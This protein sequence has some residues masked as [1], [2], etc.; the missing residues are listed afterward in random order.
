MNRESDKLENYAGTR[1]TRRGGEWGAYRQCDVQVIVLRTKLVQGINEDK[2]TGIGQ[3]RE[4]VG[5]YQL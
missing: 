3:G 2:E 1:K 5:A 4:E